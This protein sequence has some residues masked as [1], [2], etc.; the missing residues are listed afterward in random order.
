M[1]KFIRTG[2]MVL[3]FIL[4]VIMVIMIS[5]E[6]ELQHSIFDSPGS[7]FGLGIAKVLT[8]VAVIASVVLAVLN[9]ASNPKGAILVGAGIVV[10][11]IVFFIG[12]AM[13]AG[14]L[15]LDYDV[16]EA[17]ESKSVGG[18][19]TLTYVM[20]IISAIVFVGALVL[21]IFKK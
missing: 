8:W 4:C 14:E 10:M 11:L 15:Y 5:T 16:T 20:G 17:S 21:N 12:K 19:I 2:F 3:I 13:D 9:L 7:V 1:N 6:T 18:L